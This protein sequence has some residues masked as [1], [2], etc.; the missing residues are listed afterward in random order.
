MLKSRD[1]GEVVVVDLTEARVLDEDHIRRLGDELLNMAMAAAADRK[2]LVNFTQV[3][4]MSSSMIGQVVRLNKRCK[5]D[6]IRL[7]LCSISG[8]I[9]EVFRIT[10]LTKLL[11]IHDDEEAA[12]AAFGK[13]G[14][15][16]R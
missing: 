12:L 15:F 6:K 4:F 16:R 10:G 3:R 11:D 8:E 7:K 9:H 5:K 13:S 14:W 1:V 2:L